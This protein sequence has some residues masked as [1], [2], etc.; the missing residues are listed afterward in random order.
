[1]ADM[2]K[3]MKKRLGAP[4]PVDDASA[5]LQAPEVAP[6]AP[7]R[8]GLPHRRGE[9]GR[10]ARRTGRTIQFSTRVSDDFD[11]RFRQV[12]KRDGLLL[13]QLLEKALDAYENR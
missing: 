1:M 13:A 12:A 11:M 5:N 10:S 3:L 7:A 8:A 2:S 6:S 9:D 4:P